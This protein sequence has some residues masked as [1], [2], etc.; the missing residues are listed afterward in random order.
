MTDHEALVAA[1]RYDPTEDTPRY[2][3]ADFI[4]GDMNRPI[5]GQFVRYQLDGKEQKAYDLMVKHGSNVATGWDWVSVKPDVLPVRGFY[6][7]CTFEYPILKDFGDF[8]LRT[9]PVMIVNLINGTPAMQKECEER[10]K[11]MNIEFKV[12]TAEFWISSGRSFTGG[13]TISGLTNNYGRSQHLRQRKMN[14]QH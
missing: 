2:A 7:E 1:I 5:Y 10:W 12:P 3:F 6:R 13:I 8:I 14:E 9:Y 4:A 11:D